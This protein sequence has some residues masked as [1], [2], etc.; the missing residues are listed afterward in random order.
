MPW[1]WDDSPAQPDPSKEPRFDVD[2]LSPMMKRQVVRPYLPSPD[3]ILAEKQRQEEENDKGILATILGLPE[4]VFFGQAIKGGVR[5]YAEEGAMGALKG[6]A[7]GTP[8]AFLY[9]FIND[10][11]DGEDV[12]RET[13]FAQ[14][15]SAFGEKDVEGG[16]TNGLINLFGEIA[17]SPIELFA[18]PFALTKAGM[19]AGKVATSGETLAKALEMGH[20]AGLT[21]KVPFT[22]LALETNLGFKSGFILQAKMLDGIGDLIRKNPLT[23]AVG[24]VF[25]ASWNLPTLDTGARVKQ[26]FEAA[27]VGKRK[28]MTAAELAFNQ[29][30][31]ETRRIA[32]DQGY[33]AILTTLSEIGAGKVDFAGSVE[34]GVKALMEADVTLRAARRD[35]ILASD[36]VLSELWNKALGGDDASIRTLYGKYSHLPLTDSML[37]RAGLQAREGVELSMIGTVTDREKAIDAVFAQTPKNLIEGGPYRVGEGRDAAKRAMPPGSTNVTLGQA[38]RADI[39]QTVKGEYDAVLLGARDKVAKDYVRLMDDIRSGKVKQA[40]VDL[41]LSFHRNQMTKIGLSDIANGFMSESLEPFL[42]L[43]APHIVSEEASRLISEQVKTVFKKHDYGVRRDLRDMLAVEANAVLRDFGSKATGFFSTKELKAFEKKGHVAVMQKLF[44]VPFIR[45]L[46]KM[47]ANAAEALLAF[48]DED[49]FF[50]IAP[51]DNLFK[52]LGSSADKQALRTFQLA[53]FNDG[54][55]LVDEVIS[56]GDF[57]KRQGDFGP[58]SVFV[59]ETKSGADALNRGEAV[60]EYGI[61]PE[62]AATFENVSFAA[63]ENFYAQTQAAGINA[64]NALEDLRRS[65]NLHEGALDDELKVTEGELLATDR[66]KGSIRD[67]KNA[68]DAE[69]EMREVLAFHKRKSSRRALTTENMFAQQKYAEIRSSVENEWRELGLTSGRS[70]APGQVIRPKK[71]YLYRSFDSVDDLKP[72]PFRPGS[73]WREDLPSDAPENMKVGWNP[74]GKAAS[75]TFKWANLDRGFLVEFKAPSAADDVV[76]GGAYKNLGSKD[77][78]TPVGRSGEPERIFISDDSPPLP[79]D[80][81]ALRDAFPNVEIVEVPSVFGPKDKPRYVGETNYFVGGKSLGSRAG[82]ADFERAVSEAVERKYQDALAHRQWA[83]GMVDVHRGSIDSILDEIEEES[84]RV[85][86]GY[87]AQRKLVV[88]QGQETQQNV[89]RAYSRTTD[90]IASLRS[91]GLDPQRV[92]LE[93]A[94]Q[95]RIRENG[96]MALDEAKATVVGAKPDGTPITLYDRVFARLDPNTK[97]KVVKRDVWDGYKGFVDDMRKPDPWRTHGVGR[98]LDHIKSTW[99]AHTIYG[100]LFAATRVRNL[101]QN[102]IQ[103]MQ[104]GIFS[105]GAQMESA[106]ISNALRKM[107]GGDATA[108]NALATRTMAGTNLTLRQVL[109]LAIENGAM[110]YAPAYAAEVGMAAHA[111]TR[112]TVQGAAR[113]LGNYLRTDPVKAIG[114]VILPPFFRKGAA[115][116]PMYRFGA[117]MESGL[118][119]WQRLAAFMGGLKKGMSPEA[120]GQAVRKWLYDSTL[121]LTYT[122]RSLFRRVMPFYSFQKYALRTT[123]EMYLTRPAT[124]TSMEKAR[125]VVNENNGVENMETVL[126]PFVT[127]QFGIVTRRDKDGPKVMLFGGW[128]N[129]GEAA[130]VADAFERDHTM[131][132]GNTFAESSIIRYVMNKAHPAIRAAVEQVA[133][134]NFMSDRPITQPGDTHGEMFGIVMPKRMIRTVQ[135]MR[136]LN[137]LDKLNVFN[138]GEF[139]SIVDGVT[140]SATGGP[141]QT[142]LERFLGSAFSPAPFPGERP[143]RVEQEGQYRQAKAEESLRRTKGLLLRRIAQ[144]DSMP[145][146]AT[147]IRNLG[148]EYRKVAAEALRRQ[149]AMSEFDTLKTKADAQRLR[150]LQLTR[151]AGTGQAREAR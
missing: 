54:S 96:V 151:L 108:F 138:F 102:A 57:A 91:R 13:S 111:A 103:Q 81:K 94:T 70:V 20:R 83:E 100:P 121:P 88:K 87:K 140:R 79:E 95:R 29:L 39:A 80:I 25:E 135:Q 55:P 51:V 73:G 76:S 26:A 77:W 46:R 109:D 1:P 92:V 35:A 105:P 123:A 53:A 75:Q 41:W 14:I 113:D 47:D 144:P 84:Y 49:T 142:V 69:R 114:D 117:Q 107:I 16:W 139:K 64:E 99:A 28:F 30:P 38:E 4:K 128:F 27:D 44:D 149:G 115:D 93:A 143:I 147:D 31:L 101:M 131:S 146:K 78:S 104:A 65:R 24:K 63:R 19:V 34:G 22:K 59:L 134:R 21:L 11:W 129:I 9:D 15:R 23:K 122:E 89:R 85:S 17:L 125:Q 82:N 124:I 118:D 66:M 98:T 119:Q 130:A 50:R 120:S 116:S 90:V 145:T 67:L 97:I 58:D 126:P 32:H 2:A 33:G 5:G 110:N 40:D 3:E 72:S 112:G 7:Q 150:R 62:H 133:N 52:R 68:K 12:S 106:S 132:G 86:G 10:A 43:Y 61:K 56:V 137:E 18:A 42:G 8:F 37:E 148:D 45:K 36:P 6:F 136:F 71:G 60:M 74:K 48:H 141:E 127:E